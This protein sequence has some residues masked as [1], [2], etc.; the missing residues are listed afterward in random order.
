VILCD[1]H[2]LLPQAGATPAIVPTISGR[3]WI[4]G[5]SQYGLDPADPFPEGYVLS[6]TWHR[7]PLG[8]SW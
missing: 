7:H 1:D 6:D 3:A 4:T 5:I 2:L 8:G